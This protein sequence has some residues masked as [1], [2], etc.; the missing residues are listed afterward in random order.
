MKPFPLGRSSS[1]ELLESRI[2]PAAITGRV[3]TYTDQDGDHVTVTFSKGTL[4]EGM[5]TFNNAFAT[6]GP[7]QLQLIHIPFMGDFQG[8]NL[9]VAVKSAAGG[10]GRAAIGYIDAEGVD[11]G[12]VSIAG[13]LGRIDAGLG[14]FTVPTVAIKSL[15][16]ES[17]GLCG[18]TSQSTLASPTL[19]SEFRGRLNKV[20]IATDVTGVQFEADGLNGTTLAFGTIGAITV[21]GSF[22]LSSIVSSAEIDSVTV[23][24]SFVDSSIHPLTGVKSVTVH[25]TVNR[26]SISATADIGTVTIGG[27]FIGNSV[28]EST[29]GNI[30]KVST[31]GGFSQ[32]SKVTS[33][34]GSVGAIKIGATMDVGT[35]SGMTGVGPVTIGGAFSGASAVT[36]A[37]GK[38]GAV[39]I[40]RDLT[41]NSSLSGA[42]GIGAVTIGGSVTD[43]ASVTSSAGTITSLKI[44]G[45]LTGGTCKGAQ[46]IG[47]VTIGGNVSAGSA[48]SSAMGSIGAVKIAGSMFGGGAISGN[49]GVTSVTVGGDVDGSTLESASGTL[50]AIKVGGDLIDGSMI[51]AMAKIASVTVAG[52]VEGSSI[53]VGVTGTPGAVSIGAIKVGGNWSASDLSAGVQ[54]VNGDGYGNNDDKLVATSAKVTSISIGGAV[55]GTAASGD[56]FAFESQTIGKFTI[57]KVAIPLASPVPLAPL[58][59]DVAIVLLN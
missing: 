13:D 49:S 4:A 47:A 16:A 28:I 18:T 7:Q 25:G 51:Q 27:S 5:F 53:L 31:G 6:T 58:T 41:H 2:A 56:T 21:G 19:I 30:S 39:K 3:L 32:G 43:G 29:G 17:M 35:I 42:D 14:S 45:D 23:G 36:S 48:V 24:G 26:S 22:E 9:T 55:A 59:G 11:L 54:D 40:G 50:G 10:D 33:D 38:I 1:L 20:A 37:A 57:N 12:T 34:I 44:A 52:S 15:K 46:G 8:T